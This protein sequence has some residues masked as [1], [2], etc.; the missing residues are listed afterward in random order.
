[1]AFPKDDDAPDFDRLI[2]QA[3]AAVEALRDTYRVQ[4]SEDVGQLCDIWARVEAEGYRK[5]EALG[6]SRLTHVVTAGGGSVNEAW[7]RIRARYLGVPVEASRQKEAAYGA[8]LLALRSATPA[9][10]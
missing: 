5:L 2:A 6:A 9:P 3:E 8:A 10:R 1:M 7:N 4:L